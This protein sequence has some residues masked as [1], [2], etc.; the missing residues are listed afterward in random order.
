MIQSRSSKANVDII[1]SLIKQEDIFEKYLRIPVQFHKPVCNTLRD[2]KNPDCSFLRPNKHKYLLFRDFAEERSINCFELVKRVYH[3]NFN[4]ALQHIVNDF[5]LD[6]ISLDNK[7]NHNYTPIIL[8]KDSIIKQEPQIRIKR[9]PFTKAH[10]DYW[11]QYHLDEEDLI[12]HNVSAIKCYWYNDEKRFP[13]GLGFAYWFGDY[14]YKL[15]FP[16]VKKKEG[17]R[18]LQNRGDIIQGEDQLTWN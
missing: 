1:L 2:D 17:L 16:Q 4:D 6:G 12:K 11:K 15:Y 18:F 5:N 13:K 3:C 9:I 14:N 7:I 8:P 10:L